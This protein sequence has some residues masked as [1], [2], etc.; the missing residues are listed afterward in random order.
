V[1]GKPFLVALVAIVSLALALRLYNLGQPSFWNDESD[2]GLQALGLLQKGIPQLPSGRVEYE[3]ILS[4]AL[5]A[6]AWIVGGQS[7]LSARVVSVIFG[8]STIVI[9]F[10]VGRVA[11][12]PGA[13]LLA[14][15][16]LGLSTW[17]LAWSRQARM[18]A[19]FQFFYLSASLVALLLLNSGNITRKRL[20]LTMVALLVLGGLSSYHSV[21]LYGSLLV[22]LAAV[23]W[24]PKVLGRLSRERLSR[25][26]A[27]LCLVV[28]GVVILLWS[29]VMNLLGL[30]VVHLVAIA[31]GQFFTL[32]PPNS[33]LGYYSVFDSFLFQL[34]PYA[35]LLAF[36]GIVLLGRRDWRIAVI[37][38]ALFGVP[39][40]TYSILFAS[41]TTTIIYL[42]Y[43]LPE[44]PIIFVLASVTVAWLAGALAHWAHKTRI[45]C[46][47]LQISTAFRAAIL[48]GLTSLIILVP[49]SGFQP[50]LPGLSALPE[51]QPSYKMAANYVKL[52]MKPG[53]AVGA[54]WPENTFYYFGHA[55]YWI[56]SNQ[57]SITLSGRQDGPYVRY[58]Y[59]GSLL[60][61]NSTEMSQAM[62]LHPRGWLLLS[63]YDQSGISPE[64]WGFIKTN[65]ILQLAASDPTLRTYFWDTGH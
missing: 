25:R 2:T 9:I 36:P 14:S 34:H 13:G 64:L 12:G 45:A 6:L 60:I 11:W 30:G 23:H 41:Y 8:A 18:Y 59:T 50:S 22:A 28:G 49:Q 19:Q 33:T 47:H 42:R 32:I 53:D 40:L 10:L 21:L 51:P 43:I 29:G 58:Y 57:L 38:A 27:V 7:D 3:A 46:G 17:N 52:L 56:V 35:V 26:I 5:I 16:K 24:S 37:L 54:I 55:E 15:L 44:L 65:M 1:R 20:T 4:P 63:I 61:K 31:T 39:Y 48:V 62:S